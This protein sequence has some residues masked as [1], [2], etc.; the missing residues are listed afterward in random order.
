MK[1]TIEKMEPESI[2][3]AQK[4]AKA[5]VSG[6]IEKAEVVYE[7]AKRALV[8]A[9]KALEQAKAGI[10]NFEEVKSIIRFGWKSVMILVFGSIARSEKEREKACCFRKRKK[11]EESKEGKEIIH[12]VT[13]KNFDWKEIVGADI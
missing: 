5:E 11:E 10:D 3:E 9:E 12:K 13:S 7:E 4:Q 2:E 1:E 8:K 6:N